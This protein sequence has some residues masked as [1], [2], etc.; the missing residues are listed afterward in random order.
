VSLAEASFTASA[1][2]PLLRDESRP[3]RFNATAK[4]AQTMA[5]LLGLKFP[6]MLMHFVNF[7][8]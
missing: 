5:I 8:T 2:I 1:S 7:Q 6:K 4:A 3:Y